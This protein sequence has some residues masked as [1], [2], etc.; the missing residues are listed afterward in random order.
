MT[1]RWGLGNGFTQISVTDLHGN[2]V[3]ASPVSATAGQHVLHTEAFAAGMYVVKV[4]GKTG[5][6]F[7]ENCRVALTG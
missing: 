7:T 4:Y 3:Y 6:F 1:V 5:E 2:T